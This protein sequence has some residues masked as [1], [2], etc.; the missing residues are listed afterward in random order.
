MDLNQ[1]LVGGPSQ[2]ASDIHIK[3]GAPPIL[4]GNGALKAWNKLKPFASE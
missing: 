1:I 4:Q 2:E 3:A